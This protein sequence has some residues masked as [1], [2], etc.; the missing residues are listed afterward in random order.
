MK[1][2]TCLFLLLAV[3]SL[4]GSADCREGPG[5][6]SV[7][8]WMDREVYRAGENV[9]VSVEVKNLSGKALLLVRPQ[10]GSERKIR[11]PYCLF[12]VR[13]ARGEEVA[14]KYPIDKTVAPLEPGAFFEVKPGEVTRLYATPYSLSEHMKLE[15]GAYILV[16][17]YSTSSPKE[18]RWYGLYTDDYWDGERKGNEFWKKRGAQMTKNREL[19]SRVPSLTISSKEVRFTG[20]AVFLRQSACPLR[21]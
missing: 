21:C 16:F 10:E 14:M 5:I 11:Y 4:Q 13:N 6:L 15:P 18:S 19:L 3:I 8:A 7:R 9:S 20:S 17:S 1:D 12:E 2:I